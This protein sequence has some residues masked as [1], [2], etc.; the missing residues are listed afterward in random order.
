MAMKSWHCDH[1]GAA[2]LKSEID[3]KPGDYFIAQALANLG[4]FQPR[5]VLDFGC[6]SGRLVRSLRGLGLDASG[7]DIYPSWQ[8]ADDPC[9]KY[10]SAID[11]Q[12]P[13]R[14]PYP[15]ETCLRHA[16]EPKH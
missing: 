13:L 9:V 8:G 14:L 7:C 1:A 12:S 3:P 11:L 16:Q 5:K 10:L 4:G 6:G 15:D 2:L